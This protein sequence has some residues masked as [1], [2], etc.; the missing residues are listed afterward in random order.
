[1]NRMGLGKVLIILGVLSGVFVFVGIFLATFGLFFGL[2]LFMVGLAL[3][4][5]MLFMIPPGGFSGVDIR[6]FI[7]C[8]F[9]VSLGAACW[10]SGSRSM[11]IVKNRMLMV[12]DKI[13]EEVRLVRNKEFGSEFEDAFE[14]T[15]RDLSD[16]YS[17]IKYGGR[18][19]KAL[20]SIE[21]AVD[22]LATA[23]QSDDREKVR[24]STAHLKDGIA[25]LRTELMR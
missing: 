8:F 7:P 10:I 20:R 2:I 1:M 4:P 19:D 11:R 17:Q 16:L 5:P 22:E 23:V 21:E 3:F 25:D 18:I 13:K 9:Y 24:K 15:R 6:A 12:E 14:A